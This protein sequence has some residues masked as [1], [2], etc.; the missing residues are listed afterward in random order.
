MSIHFLCDCGRKLQAGD[1]YAGRR[2][3]CPDCNREVPIPGPGPEAS[4]PAPSAVVPKGLSPEQDFGGV[5]IKSAHGRTSG[6]AIASLLM[7]VLSILTFVYLPYY[8]CLPGLAL[9]IVGLVSINQSDGRLSGGGLAIGGII[10]SAIGAALLPVALALMMPDLEEAHEEARRAACAKNLEH[11]GLALRK[12]HDTKGHYPPAAITKHGTPLLS[13]R[14]AILP[15]IEQKP[16][17]DKFHLDEPWDGAHNKALLPRMPAPFA[18]PNDPAAMPT[19]KGMT[20][21]RGLAGPGTFLDGEHGISLPDLSDGAATTLAVVE[22]TDA[23]PWTKPDELAYHPEGVLPKIGSKHPGGF[24]ALF[25][26][27]SVRLLNREDYPAPLLRGIITRNG[28][29]VV[30]SPAGP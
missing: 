2:T 5:P 18:C 16:L 28:G 8:L 22:A 25:A 24:N 4:P 1:D 19:S 27:G 30:P 12:A 14:V 13:W 6:M 7:G 21:Y 9:G 20:T 26:D 10:T 11:I 17:Y 15:Y 29:E 3:R 23:V